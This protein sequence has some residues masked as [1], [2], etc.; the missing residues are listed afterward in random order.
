MK[1]KIVSF[2]MTILTMLMFGLLCFFGIIIYNE[3]NKTNIVGEVQQF[4]SNIT[5]TEKKAENESE[6]EKIEISQ[7]SNKVEENLN[8]DV[9]KNNRFFY[10]QLDNYSKIIYNA[11]EKN[12]EN[13]KSGIYELNLGTSFSQVLSKGNGESLLGEYYQSA[14]EAYAYDNPDVF[15]IEFPKLLLN[16]ETTIRGNEKT[17]KVFIN[18]GNNS[19]YL[20][21]EFPSK[22]MINNAINEIEKIKAYFVQNKKNSTYENIKLVHD[23][24][25]E[26]IEYEQSILSDNVYSIYGALINKRCVCEGY[27]KSFKYLMDALDITCTITIGKA[28]NSD[29]KT[30]NHAWNYV[31]LNDKWYGVDC[32]WDDPIIIG[33]GFLSNSSKYKYFLKGKNE[34]SKT[35][36]PNGQFTENGKIF[37]FPSLSEV[38]YKEL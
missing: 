26:S 32:T 24:L 12:K 11:L 28:T 1:S 7:S 4:V 37:E 17:Y 16:M 15:Y 29:G 13:M 5:T 35:H 25:V 10:N 2:I 9:G 18:S 34:F 33:P 22:E 8:N 14:I 31:Q 21:D 38:D 6:P 36:V 27:A 3:F 23:Y 20:K 30:E 19:N